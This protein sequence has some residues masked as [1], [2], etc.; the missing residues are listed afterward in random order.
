ME[1]NTSTS[2]NALKLSKRP[3]I[4]NDAQLKKISSPIVLTSNLFPM[5]VAEKSTVGDYHCFQYDVDFEPEVAED[6]RPLR[7]SIFKAL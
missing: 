2:N 7:Y 3:A 4:A 6:N 1:S 5:T